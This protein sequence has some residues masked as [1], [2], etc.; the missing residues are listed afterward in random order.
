M[1]EDEKEKVEDKLK[2]RSFFATIFLINIFSIIIMFAGTIQISFKQ[3][4]MVYVIILPIL[5][6][7][8]I[9]EVK[10]FQHLK[11]IDIF[12]RENK[13]ILPRP[14]I[15]KGFFISLI[16][17]VG[18][19]CLRLLITP[20][21]PYIN[22]IIMINEINI[23]TTYL[24][25]IYAILLHIFGII[26]LII[27]ILYTTERAKLKLNKRIEC[28]KN[29]KIIEKIYNISLITFIVL[30]CFPMLMIVFGPPIEKIIMKNEINIKNI[31]LLNSEILGILYMVFFMGSWLTAAT[32]WA[33]HLIRYKKEPEFFLLSKEKKHM[34]GTTKNKNNT[35]KKTKLI[36]AVIYLIEFFLPVIYIILAAI[37]GPIIKKAMIVNEINIS[38]NP[39]Y[40][41]TAY[42]LLLSITALVT[43]IIYS[44][45]SNTKTK[46]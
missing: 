3:Y 6:G 41:I 40:V 23:D 24:E 9:L 43:A 29:R 31:S 10:L 1:K 4:P 7:L 37:L 32:T 25:L 42:I 2:E 28:E 39:T 5:I 45:D 12:L 33:I 16:T 34:V 21:E 8:I 17:L 15:E 13:E 18:I 30:I 11:R 46:E 20:L 19:F 36:F 38:I 22:K 27:Y 14:K 26:T 44:K 35:L